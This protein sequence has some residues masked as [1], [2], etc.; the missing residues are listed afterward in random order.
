MGATRENTIASVEELS[1]SGRLCKIHG[2]PSYR[3]LGLNLQIVDDVLDAVD[4]LRDFG[5]F[6]F[7]RLA[8]HNSGQ[9]HGT[10]CGFNADSCHGAGF[11][12]RQLGFDRACNCRVINV[13]S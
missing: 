1:L 12:D 9:L 11:I 10:P 4:A 3:L 6:V 2:S 5:R 13:L 8:I 7:C